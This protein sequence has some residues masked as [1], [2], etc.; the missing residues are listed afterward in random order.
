MKMAELADPILM[1]EMV[2]GF[3][4]KTL[5]TDLKLP[6]GNLESMHPMSK[7]VGL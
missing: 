4:V 3:N 5:R 1:G 7:S 2:V 6:K